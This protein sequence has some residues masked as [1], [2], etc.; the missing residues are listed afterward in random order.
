[1]WNYIDIKN[2]QFPD[3]KKELLTK[4]EKKVWCYSD[5][6][7]KL[8]ADSI[9]KV[10][11]YSPLKLNQNDFQHENIEISPITQNA[12]ETVYDNFRNSCIEKNQN[13]K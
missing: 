6:K 5:K 9:E 11:L 2:A 4:F 8:H 3:K 10:T 7:P 13:I 1:M 12:D